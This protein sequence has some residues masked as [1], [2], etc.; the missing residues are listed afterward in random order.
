MDWTYPPPLPPVVKSFDGAE[1]L[2][3]IAGAE[4]VAVW[5]LYRDA[6]LW[7]D[8]REGRRGGLFAGS[9]VEHSWSDTVLSSAPFG[10]IARSLDASIRSAKS[11][12]RRVATHCTALSEWASEAGYVNTQALFAGLAARVWPRNPMMAV[13]AGRAERNAGRYE[14]AAEWFRRAIGL[15][16]RTGDEA[17]YATAYMGWGLLERLR[18]RTAAARMMYVRAWRAADRAGL[19]DRVARARHNLIALTVEGSEFSEGQAH[20]EA[21][22]RLYERSSPSLARLAADAACYW[23]W[24][25]YFS[26]ALPL[27]EAAIPRIPGRLDR[28]QVLANAARAAAAL[29]LAER[30][31]ADLQE[32]SKADDDN[33]PPRVWVDLAE[34]AR[35]LGRLRQALDLTG[36][37]LEGAGRRREALT[38]VAARK[39][40]QAIEAEQPPDTDRHAPLRLRRFAARFR[41]RVLALPLAK[42]IPG[43]DEPTSP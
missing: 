10:E 35:S 13:A 30:Y 9:L 36:R 31:D 15:A 39:L 20:I 40:L 37:A 14:R 32:L 38:E 12:Y 5:Q 7:H 17:A 16:R 21:A 33:L 27:Y 2:D 6:L 8:A 28:A 26:T 29:G 34:G 24:Q 3:E 22:Y 18:N 42:S 4:G 19:R 41:E 43:A 1:V 25:G 11:D 23:A